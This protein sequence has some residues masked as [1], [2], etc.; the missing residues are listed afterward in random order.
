MSKKILDL[1]IELEEI[2][3]NKNKNLNNLFYMN[4]NKEI[5]ENIQ[6]KV[7]LELQIL[8]LNKLLKVQ[9]DTLCIINNNTSLNNNN[10]ITTSI[11]T[12]EKVEQVNT[13]TLV[14]NKYIKLLA[15]SFIGGTVISGLGAIV[16]ITNYVITSG[17]GSGIGALYSYYDNKKKIDVI[18]I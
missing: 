10:L 13:S 5:K 7:N 17:A 16:G 15:F 14:N 18:N 6:E 1:G 12:L 9:Q 11:K 8:E 3:D 4:N 2:K